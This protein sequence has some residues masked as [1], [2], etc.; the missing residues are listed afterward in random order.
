M[1]HLVDP[2]L[3]A[4][5]RIA[6]SLRLRFDGLKLQ[7]QLAEELDARGT[8]Q[9]QIRRLEERAREI[10]LGHT[11]HV[12]KGEIMSVGKSVPKKTQLVHSAT[13]WSTVYPILSAITHADANSI[14][15]LVVEDSHATEGQPAMLPALIQNML[16]FAAV[17]YAR[18][19]WHVVGFYGGC[20]EARKLRLNEAYD[21]AGTV[22]NE[23]IRFG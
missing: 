23:S 18:T 14:Y 22:K 16:L 4:I 10:G 3:R 11:V 15:Q 9:A 20:N 21:A 5:D 13:K 19:V 8:C 17:T 6:R 1:L 12:E 2:D 7:M